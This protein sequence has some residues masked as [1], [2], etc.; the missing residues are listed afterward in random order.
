MCL[1]ERE[2]IFIFESCVRVPSKTDFSSFFKSKEITANC[3][4]VINY[5]DFSVDSNS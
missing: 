4:V 5:V 3:E 2:H 1:C